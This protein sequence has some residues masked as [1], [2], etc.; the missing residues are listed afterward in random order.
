[1]Y[2]TRDAILAM[3]RE[4]AALAPRSTLA[5]SF[6]LPPDMVDGTE[7][8]AYEAVL[9]AAHAAGSPFVSL[10]RPEEMLALGQEAGFRE[11]HYAGTDE[12]T[13]RYFTARSDGLKPAVGECFLV[14]TV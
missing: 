12:L 9:K 14:A 7:R 10:L 13:R 5:L 6:L 11:V 4:V 2:L 1:M 3:L 8:G